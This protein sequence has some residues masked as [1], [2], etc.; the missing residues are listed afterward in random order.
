[1]AAEI[2][3]LA[4][5]KGETW[6]WSLPRRPVI[7]PC[8]MTMLQ[9]IIMAFGPAKVAKPFSKEVFKVIRLKSASE[10]PTHN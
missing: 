8:A 10:F 2:G 4:P 9:A 3:C 5:M 6:P 7:V 1:M